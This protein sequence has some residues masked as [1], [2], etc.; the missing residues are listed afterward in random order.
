MAQGNVQ[1]LTN[2]KPQFL[3][4]N[5]RSKCQLHDQGM[6]N[7]FKSNYRSMTLQGGMTLFKLY[8]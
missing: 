5:T 2:I 8:W 6:V 1:N 3:P 4:S 7:K